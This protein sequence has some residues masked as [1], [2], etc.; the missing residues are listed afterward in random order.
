MRLLEDDIR[1]VRA[2][3]DVAAVG[4]ARARVAPS[5]R[6]P[7][8]PV[9]RRG[10][11]V[12][13]SETAVELGGP[14]QESVALLLWTAQ[15]DMIRDGL[16]TVVG[17]DLRES[18]GG[19]LPF[20]KAVI[21]GVEGFDESNCVE[22]HRELELLRYELDLDGYMMR[23]SSLQGKE[24]GRVSRQAVEGGFSLETLAAGSMRLYRSIPYVSA[25]EVIVVTSSREAVRSLA[26]IGDMASR[27]IRALDKMA[28]EPSR[29]CDDCDFNDVCR[30]V[31]DLRSRRGTRRERMSH[32]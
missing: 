12:L 19:H 7:G 23:G 24:W 17:P 31:D 27:R 14:Q 25:V 22:R 30:E 9:G 15:V 13:Q 10:N 2:C 1:L 11:V 20:G 6:V 26:P 18:V 5:A 8:W 3:V 32:A 21:L 16:I 29:E 4:G 28:T